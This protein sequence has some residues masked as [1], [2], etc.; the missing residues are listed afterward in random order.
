[1]KPT[2]FDYEIPILEIIEIQIE[3]G[4]EASGNNSGMNL[5]SWEFI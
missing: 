1:M 3:H 2:T 5:P 4:Y